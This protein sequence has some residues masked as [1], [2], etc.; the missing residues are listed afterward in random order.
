MTNNNLLDQILVDNKKEIID[1]ENSILSPL[2]DEI[3]LIN[4]E[5]IRSFVRSV[6]LK[7][8]I[9]WSIPSSFSGK[10]HPKD[11]HGPGGNVLHT[12]RATRIA[13]TMVDSYSLSS[14]ERDVILA[15]CL[16]HDVTKGIPAEEDGHFHYDPMHPYTVNQ[17]V[18]ECQKFDKQYGKDSLSSSLFISEDSLQTILR[19]VR[20][21]L[22]PWSPVPETFPITYMDYIVHI[23]DNIASKIHEYILDSDLINPIFTY[24]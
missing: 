15:A 6:L 14:E 12:K 3:N 19:L 16:I 9:F 11:E 10:H 18:T 7:A 5:G 2:L 20:C 22:G 21:H 8:G 13:D 17:F 4:D 23:A 24:E 1:E